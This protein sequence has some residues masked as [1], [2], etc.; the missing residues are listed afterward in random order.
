MVEKLVYCDR[1]PIGRLIQW[2]FDYASC[3]QVNSFTF[4]KVIY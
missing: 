4:L 3:V 1:W 2:I